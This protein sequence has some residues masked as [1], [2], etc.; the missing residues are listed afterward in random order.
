[1]KINYW[2]KL[3]P[4]ITY[5]VYN[6]GVDGINL[7]RQELDYLLFLNLLKKYLIQYVDV[8]AYC[9]MPN[10]YHLLIRVKSLKDYSDILEK[11]NTQ[12]ARK[13]L[14]DEASVDTFLSDQRRRMFSS[15]SLKTNKKDKRK[16]PLFSPKVKRVSVTNNDRIRNLICYLHHNPI[17]HRFRK[18]YAQWPYSSYHTL[19]S[20]NPTH[21][22]REH[23][24]NLMSGIEGFDKHHEI[25]RLSKSKE[26]IDSNYL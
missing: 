20:N 13:L 21:L 5:H 16:G 26:L 11:E 6:R 23:V 2:Q 18:A 10:H 15:Y 14:K 7:F 9:L 3:E 1:M 4:G 19:R 8:L 17:H 22:S 24:L 12:A 25:F